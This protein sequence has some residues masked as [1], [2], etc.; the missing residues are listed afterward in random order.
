MMMLRELAAGSPQ[1]P[2]APAAEP[3]PAPRAGITA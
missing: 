3:A 2:Q 1:R